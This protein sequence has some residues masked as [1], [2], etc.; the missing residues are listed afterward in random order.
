MAL[1]VLVCIPISLSLAACV[2]GIP[3]PDGWEPTKVKPCHV[4]VTTDDSGICMTRGEF[5][6]WRRL[7]G[8]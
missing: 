8:L 6:E 4:V 2:M 1:R 3:P 7:N 5:A